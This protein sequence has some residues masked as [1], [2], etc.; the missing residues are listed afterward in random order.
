MKTTVYLVLILSAIVIACSKKSSQSPIFKEEVMGL[1]DSVQWPFYHGVASGDPLADRVILWTR[2]TPKKITPRILVTWEVAEDA[3]FS[4]IYR[5]DTTSTTPSRDYTVKV[6]VDALKP[7]ASYYYRFKALDKLSPTGRTKT[8][9]V[10]GVDSVTLAVVSCSNWEFGYFNAYEK[11]AQRKNVHAVVHLGDYI[12]EYGQGGYGDTTIG[13]QHLPPYEIVTL[14]DYRTRYSQYHL[15]KGLQQVRQN[16]PFI[17]IWDDHEVA[18]NVY[19]QG[20]QNHQPE[21][22]GDFSARKKAAVQAY[23]EWIPIREGQ[24]HY[25]SFQFGNLAELLMLDERLEGRTK[26]ADSLNDPLYKSEAQTMLGEAQLSWLEN[27]LKDRGTVWKVV[28]NQ[29]IF[30]TVD[31]SGPYPKQPRNLD[32]WD[33]YPAEQEKVASFIKDNAIQ[34]VIFVTGDTHASWAFEVTNDIKQYNA[35]TSKGSFA[36]EFGTT[37]VSSSNWNEYASD[38]TTRMN[39]QLLFKANPHL[40]YGNARDHGYLLVSL[41]PDKTK[42]EWWYVETLRKP[43]GGELLGKKMV[44][45]TNSAKLN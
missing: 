26:P 27:R 44:V 38:D 16:H 41:Y 29:V 18:N 11:I 34:N 5:W 42:A 28:G 35:K 2:V 10:N 8:L 23:Y 20:A 6:D 37:S 40:K 9:P 30:S 14:K 17:T 25:R 13:R 31:Q 15:D 1:Y 21:K 22:E 3:S 33:G 7:G 36:V 32:S 12:Y 19:T 43:G 4:S 45:R 24:K 39:E